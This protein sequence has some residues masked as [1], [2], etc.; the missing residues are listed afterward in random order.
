MPDTYH[1]GD[2]RRELIAQAAN[3]LGERGIDSFS[4]REVARRAGVSHAAPTHHFGDTRGLLTAVAADG[5]DLLASSLEACGT[6]FADA[7][8]AYLRFALEYP[9]RYRAMFGAGIRDDA[10]PALRAARARATT[11]LRSGAA[12][13]IP[14]ATPHDPSVSTRAM[15]AFA[16]V[17]GFA[18]LWQ[19]GAF[20]VQHAADAPADPILTLRSMLPTLW[21]EQTRL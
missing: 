18:D 2:L 8:E 16:F 20:T 3:L 7:A 6:D 12:T 5:F 11:A 13:T 10:D 19:Q 4:L 21:S 14:G 15:A 9:G 17:H 1:H